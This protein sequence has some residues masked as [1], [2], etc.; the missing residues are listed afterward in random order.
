V[1]L[2][3]PPHDGTDPGVAPRPSSAPG[4]SRDRSRPIYKR[5]YF[6][7]GIGAVVA[8]GVAVALVTRDPGVDHVAAPPGVPV[9]DLSFP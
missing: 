9:Y 5:W 1:G 3:T 2:T 4:G 7:A 6:W 8:G